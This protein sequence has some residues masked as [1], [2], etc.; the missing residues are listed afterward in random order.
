MQWP[1]LGSMRDALY[2]RL[3]GWLP[4]PLYALTL[5]TFDSERPPQWEIA[6]GIGLALAGVALRGWARIHI[7]RSSDTRRLHARRLVTSGPYALLRNPLYVGNIAIATGLAVLIGARGWAAALALAVGLHYDRVVR[8][9]ER[10][11]EETFG[12]PY[13][14]YCTRVRRWWP[15]P[16]DTGEIRGALQSLRREWR[17]TALALLGAAL[18]LAARW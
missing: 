3:R 11:L 18:A 13:K 14:D 7:G 2:F 15:V 6:L 5:L 16:R 10:M 17:I 8:A 4:M 1:T 9:E 12:A